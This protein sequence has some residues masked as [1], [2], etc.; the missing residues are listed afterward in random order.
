MSEKDNSTN[1]DR[2]KSGRPFSPVNYSERFQLKSPIQILLLSTVIAVLITLAPLSA[3]TTLGSSI[4]HWTS[5]TSPATGSSTPVD[6]LLSETARQHAISK[7]AAIRATPGPSASFFSRDQSDRFEV[8]TNA[9]L[10][11]NCVIFTGK[12][13]GTD[14]VRGDILLDKAIVKGL[15]KVSQRVIDNTPNLT[16]IDAKG[17]WVTPGL[18]DL[19]THLGIMST[20]ILSGA[21]DL[22]SNKGPILPYLRS[23]D[24]LNTHDDA[25]EL[26]MAGGVTSV[27]VLPGSSNA[28]GGQA[29]IVKLRK[30]KDR[31][32]SSMIVEPPYNLKASGGASDDL[33]PFRWRHMKQ[34]CGENLKLYGN[35]MDSIWS[36]RQA[37]N[38]ATRIKLSQDDYCEKVENGLWEELG[39][40]PFPENLRWEMLID[41]LRGKVKISTHC[42]E[43]VDL[44]SMVR[45]SNEFQF[46]ISS[47]H[48]AAEAYLVP[49]TLKR[50]WGGIPAVAL[51]ATNY[52]YK[53]ESYRGSEFAPRVLA[54]EGIPVIM[55]SDHPVINSRHVLYEAQQAH[56]FGLQP[57]LALA[58][59]TS[60]PA[61][62]AGLSHRI[63]I[64]AEGADAD[65]VMWDSHPLRLGATP[66]KVWIDG[67][68]QIPLPAKDGSETHVEIGKGKDGS[69]WRYPPH[70]PHW[71]KERQDAVAWDGLPPLQGRKIDDDYVTFTNVKDVWKRTDVGNIQK[72]TLLNSSN[73]QDGD[74][75][76]VIVQKGKIVCMGAGCRRAFA[77]SH[78][79]DLQ[80]GSIGPGMMTYG[81]PLGLEEIASEPSTSNGPPLDAF[82]Q[83]TP[84]ILDDIGGVIR[85]MDGLII[86]YRSGVTLATTSMA[87]PIYLAGPE[88]SVIGGLSATFRTGAAH[89]ME[90]GAVI[91]DTSALHVVVGRS[92][93]LLKQTSVS[94]QISGL[95]RLLYGWELNDRET[96]V[97]FR[98]AAEGI[99]PLVIEVDSAD[100]MANLLILKADVEDKIGSRMR[101]VFSGAAEAHL[102]AKEIGDAD[103]GVILN[104]ARS[105][106][107]VWDQKRVLGGPPLT[108]DTALVQLIDNSV[109]VGLGVRSAWEARNTRFDVQ[110]AALESNG[111][112]SDY[113]AYNLVTKNLE[114]LLGIRKIDEDMRDL[115]AYQGG[116]MFEFSSKPV[117]VISPLGGYVNVF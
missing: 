2:T 51:F 31:T 112:I 117:A 15:G 6:G 56:Y 49:N 12:D 19:H 115:V 86:A 37:Y 108:N 43:A 32:P 75:G 23:I 70:T 39:S 53:R 67:I 76:V 47:F 71:D 68:L 63:G 38:E 95:R 35:R 92:H 58:A 93:P 88:S 42:Y 104:P 33:A 25:F 28:I 107:M 77:T 113:D 116:N 109:V 14:I 59:V 40:D 79:I 80:R 27:Q 64:L 7:C 10:I 97:W 62:A 17:G 60:T 26:A 98:K 5:S 48:H 21:V 101:M 114:Q 46:P 22:N 36:F 44:D 13:N 30:T 1:S 102:L 100:I 4:H 96:G 103:V 99:I 105:Y 94:T 83:N 52:R 73:L 11:R 89:A 45:L 78:E 82:R 74:A 41:V 90:R 55:K 54:D 34:A 24:G 87:K 61:K 72:T 8:G 50:T 29:F 84:R 66:L 110:W 3:F 18:V 16:V 57:H 111:K 9:T 81:S 85:A 65:V 69:Q 106:P 20:P 91:Q